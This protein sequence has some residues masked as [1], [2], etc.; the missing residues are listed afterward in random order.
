[1]NGKQAILLH[2]Q[3]GKG[4]TQ[5][6][7]TTLYGVTRLSAII[8]DLRKMGYKIESIKRKS[9]TRFGR[10]SVYSEYRLIE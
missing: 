5:I 3:S 8:F 9:I 10:T 7:A 2:L 4:I 6:E 1:M